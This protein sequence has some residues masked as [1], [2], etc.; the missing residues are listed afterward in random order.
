[1]TDALKVYR[2]LLNF[3]GRQWRDVAG[4]WFLA[5]LVFPVGILIP[6][7]ADSQLQGTF[8]QM[9]VHVL[10]LLPVLSTGFLFIPGSIAHIRRSGQLGY[11]A[12]LPIGRAPLLW[13]MGTLGMFSFVPGI[14][15]QIAAISFLWHATVLSLLPDIIAAFVGGG[16]FVLLG[17]LIG[18]HAHSTHAATL[19]GILFG[20]ILLA[21]I[22]PSDIL[23]LPAM[24]QAV[25]NIFPVNLL[26]H[27]TQIV[28]TSIQSIIDLL[29][30]ILYSVIA[31][32][33]TERFMP[34]RVEERREWLPRLAK[35]TSNP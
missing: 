16:L 13:A 31:A 22:T 29:L 19:W 3:F 20:V 27:V 9:M 25:M 12:A 14:A 23:H 15:L 1:M 18:L 5:T 21:S 8:H 4:F 30:L 26:L 33:L 34:W 24:M 28:H 11:L 6:V 2:L 32:W 35:K 17:M 10:V 7:H